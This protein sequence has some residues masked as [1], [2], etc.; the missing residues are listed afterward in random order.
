MKKVISYLADLSKIKPFPIK[1]E[2][3]SNKIWEKA[4][5]LQIHIY[6]IVNKQVAFPNKLFFSEKNEKI[7]K[8]M[9]EN[10][11]KS[12]QYASSWENYI[13]RRKLWIFNNFK[14][15]KLN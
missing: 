10:H 11:L 15:V 6:D 1:P 5:K 9:I 3:S 12:N 2:C 14:K 4:Q 7:T 8:I 13:N